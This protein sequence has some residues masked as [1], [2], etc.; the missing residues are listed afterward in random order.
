M[1]KQRKILTWKT[2]ETTLGKLLTDK[3]KELGMSM[4]GLARNINLSAGYL[5]QIEH[6]RIPPDGT[7]LR[8]LDAL[9]IDEWELPQ[10]TTS[11][12]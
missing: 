3:R 4:R 5:C 9:A 6:G 10:F 8:I 11:R 2:M 7:L 12:Q 1:G